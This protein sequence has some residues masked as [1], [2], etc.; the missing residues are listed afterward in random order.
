MTENTN[1]NESAEQK[2]KEEHN[3]DISPQRDPDKNDKD[4][5]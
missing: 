4:A 2:K 3:Q 1:Q 5:Q